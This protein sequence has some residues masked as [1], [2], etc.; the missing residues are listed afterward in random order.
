VAVLTVIS[1]PV[2]VQ[3]EAAQSAKYPVQNWK[4]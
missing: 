1:F 2:G 3:G 4:S